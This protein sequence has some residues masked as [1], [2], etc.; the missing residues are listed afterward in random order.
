MARRLGFA[1]LRQTHLPE[2]PSMG[3]IFAS[4]VAGL[5]GAATHWLL[6]MSKQQLR[7]FPEFQPYESFQRLLIS[8]LG[9]ELH[10]TAACAI[11][12]VMGGGHDR[13]N[14]GVLRCRGAITAALGL[15][16]RSGAG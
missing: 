8:L 11:S 7:L 5:S 16:R 6:M 13:A 9:G 3:R 4:A 12:L 14:A 1:R 15:G 2:H 10:P